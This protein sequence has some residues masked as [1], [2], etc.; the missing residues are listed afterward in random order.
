MD[1]WVIEISKDIWAIENSMNTENMEKEILLPRNANA[2]TLTIL[3]Y[4]KAR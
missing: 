4:Q 3:L 1:T 2:T